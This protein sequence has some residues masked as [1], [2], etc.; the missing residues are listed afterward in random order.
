M[1]MMD[2]VFLKI[3]IFYTNTLKINP[4]RLLIVNKTSAVTPI[5]QRQFPT[6]NSCPLQ[7][8]HIFNTKP[9]NLLI[10]PGTFMSCT[11]QYLLYGPDLE[12]A[13]EWVNLERAVRVM[14][15]ILL[16]FMVI[17][18]IIIFIIFF[19]LSLLLFSLLLFLLYYIATSF[20]SFFI[21][22]I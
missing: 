8:L 12:Y 6:T 3:C 10:T 18:I 19:Y 21:I 9:Q 5:G 4:P 13:N 16:L 22:I 7:V 14:S 1:Y 20:V 15:G 17:S 11:V 2:R